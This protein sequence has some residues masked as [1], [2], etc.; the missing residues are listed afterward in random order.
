[1]QGVDFLATGYTAV[2]STPSIFPTGEMLEVLD[3]SKPSIFVAAIMQGENYVRPSGNATFYWTGYRGGQVVYP[4]TSLSLPVTTSEGLPPWASV[5]VPADTFPADNEAYGSE[6]GLIIHYYITFS[7]WGGVCS[8]PLNESGSLSP[9]FFGTIK[10]PRAVDYLPDIGVFVDDTIDNTFT[11]QIEYNKNFTVT[12]PITMQSGMLQWR[13]GNEGQISSIALTAQNQTSAVIPAGGLPAQ[14]ADVQWKVSQIVMSDGARSVDTDSGWRTVTTIDAT[15]TVS[16]VSPNGAYL[17]S[18]VPNTFTWLYNIS[19]GTAQSKAVI[20]ISQDSG[21]FWST[22]ATVEGPDQS[23]S[24]PANTLP[25]GTLLWRVQGYNTDNVPSE[26]SSPA[27]IVVIGAPDAPQISSVSQVPRPLIRWQ[28][29]SQQAFEM[30]VDDWTSGPIFGTQKSYQLGFW[31]DDGIHTV[32]VR[33]QSS[34]GLWSPWA[35]TT[36]SVENVPPGEITLST[37]PVAN[38]VVLSWTPIS[39]ALYYIYRNSTII[40]S[41]SDTSWTD[42]YSVGN[43]LYQIR[44][45]VGDEYA[46]SS[47]VEG[48]S[49]CIY[50]QAVI[51]LVSPVSWMPL[52]IRQGSSPGHDVEVSKSV[53]MRYF[54]GYSL[55]SAEVSPYIDAIHTFDYSV[56]KLDRG[57][58]E[59]LRGMLGQT[60]IWKAFDG[61]CVIGALTSMSVQG[62][63][64]F[65]DI[66]FTITETNWEEY[67]NAAQ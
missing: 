27:T 31:L 30:M 55:P 59:Q 19:T 18:S 33:I 34:L 42:W 67:N 14:Q 15:P 22:I 57:K 26:W 47:Q 66:S 61:S 21:S 60:V 16:A 3:Q 5:T 54:D 9:G 28:S 45:A 11:W 58:V 56:M 63:P 1:M 50:P 46:I 20:Q 7:G 43:N 65:T 24:I 8:V 17:D 51:S 2:M 53:T 10:P 64:A 6:G 25:S 49:Q 32:S 44:A 38:G 48:L 12:T 40:A 52:W 62:N 29:E 13:E 39:G 23:T 36:I 4:Q 41:T 37:S 35:S